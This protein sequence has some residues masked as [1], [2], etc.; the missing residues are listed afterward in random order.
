MRGKIQDLNGSI[1]TMFS[2]LNRNPLGVKESGIVLLG[3]FTAAKISY[4][5]TAVTPLCE[6]DHQHQII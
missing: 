3:L 5:W 2:W 4:F 1:E 6:E